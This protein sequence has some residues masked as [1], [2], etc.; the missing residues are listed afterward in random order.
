MATKKKLYGKSRT[1][2]VL[3]SKIEMLSWIKRGKTRILVFKNIQNKVIPSDIVKILSSGS[4]RKSS[5]DY[6][7]VSRALAELESVKLILCLNPDEK[8]GR[9]YQLTTKGEKLRQELL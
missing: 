1:V 6:A 4:G 8:T 7:Q 9:L 5:S 3:K 2:P